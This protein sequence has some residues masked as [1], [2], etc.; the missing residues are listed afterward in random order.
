MPFGSVGTYA[1][2]AL[3]AK[4]A[5]FYGQNAAEFRT[6]GSIGLLKW[7]RSPQNTRGF[8]QIDVESIPGKKR[9]IAMLVDNP[10]CFDLCSLAADCNTTRVDLTNPSQEVVFELTSPPY[11]VCDGEGSAAQPVQLVFDEADLMKYCLESDTSYIT[12][13]IARF[14]KRW[15]E[16]LDQRIFEILALNIGT[17][18][19]NDSTTDLTFFTTNADTGQSN[20]N[21][22]AI[23]FLN[24]LW[25]DAGNDMQYA[26]IGGQT[27]AMIAEF[28]KWQGLNAMGVDLR[29]ID[30][31]IPFIFYDRN[32]DGILGLADF[33]QIAPGAA[34]LVTW[35]EYKGEK[36]K[37]V[38]DLYTHGTFTDPATGIEVDFDWYYDYKCKTYTYEPFLS[39][40]LAVNRPGGCG[41]GLENVNGIIQV[42]ACGQITD[43]T[44]E[45]GS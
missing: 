30:E 7:L 23:F 16:S 21:A 45:S 37:S 43:P 22:T 29:N 13:H 26:L 44:C 20:L 31:E 40:E 8:R 27:L 4:L 32:S 38:T 2:K 34:Q 24:Q 17:N 18:A 41:D 1:C 33:I 11:R 12:R 39:A 15:I 5:E 19:K 42:H 6:L 36:K 28:K 25:K 9:A 35:N 10:Y 3:E 14:N